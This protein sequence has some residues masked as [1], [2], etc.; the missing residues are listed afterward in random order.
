[1]VSVTVP[2]APPSGHPQEEETKEKREAQIAAAKQAGRAS[3]GKR[4]FRSAHSAYRRLL[5]LD[6]ANATA[7]S[8]L[9]ALLDRAGQGE[10]S[11]DLAQAHF[12]EH[13]WEQRDE[14]FELEDGRKALHLLTFRGCDK[15]RWFLQPN[16]QGDLRA[17]TRGGHFFLGYLLQTREMQRSSYRISRGNLLKEGALPEHDVLLNTIA[18]A[19]LEQVSLRTLETFLKRT[20]LP[21]V[22]A[23]DRV[24]ET[25]RDLNYQRLRDRDGISFAKTERLNREERNAKACWQAVKERGFVLPVIIR[26]V[27]THTAR[28]TGLIES[29]EAGV[30]Y[31]EDTHCASYY[32]IAFRDTRGG[33]KY[34]NK[35][36]FFCIDGTLYPV[37]SH[38]DEYWNVRGTN[39][40]TLMKKNPALMR[41]EQLFLRDPEA[42]LGERRYR[43][44]SDLHKE[45]QLD[46]WG[47]DFTETP[48]D[49]IQI[50][51]ANPCMR[52]A[53]DHAAN[54]PY[55]VPHMQAISDA[56]EA[57]IKARAASRKKDIR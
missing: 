45:M 7:A 18:D 5:D 1:M 51:E 40:L 39:R 31:F 19:D 49:G 52:H 29:E 21:I 12:E 10:A 23:P 30:A 17:I 34:Y 33:T 43:V 44:L 41:Q 3:L 24:L 56:F 20:G 6:P 48:D 26:E 53:F 32:V 42:V 27:G 15:T 9:A 16:A 55:M 38:M 46:F 54:F 36:R 4:L 28:S 13:P 37:I 50:F 22:N 25:A 8:T 11:R 47:V 14:P 35:K 2:E 57:M